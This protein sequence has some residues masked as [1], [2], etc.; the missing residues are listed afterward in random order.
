MRS[1]RRHRRQHVL[2]RFAQSDAAPVASPRFAEPGP[3]KFVLVQTAAEFA[4]ADGLLSFEEPASPSAGDYSL[5]ISQHP[6]SATGAIS[7][8]HQQALIAT[9]A[10]ADNGDGKGGY[11]GFWPTTT[12]GASI[13]A[14]PHVA[15]NASLN[16]ALNFWRPSACSGASGNQVAIVP[17][18]AGGW[19]GLYRYAA[20]GVPWTLAHLDFAGSSAALCAGWS[21]V[22][23]EGSLGGLRLTRAGAAPPA[24]IDVASPVSLAE[25]SAPADLLADFKVTQG[26]SLVD[27]HRYE[28][29][30]RH[31][32]SENFL[33]VGTVVSGGV[34]VLY[35]DQ[36]VAGV[37]TTIDSNS[38]V[39]S[40]GASKYI[41]FSAS[42]SAGS[43][44]VVVTLRGS[45]AATSG[46]LA[47]LAVA[48]ESGLDNSPT[49]V[50]LVFGTGALADLIVYP[51]RWDRLERR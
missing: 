3:G 50:P 34:V 37:R 23:G 14:G 13:E 47:S 2:E 26:G 48:V 5:R 18:A 44:A 35:V 33:A 16:D 45:R 41:Q 27:N 25:Y 12:L 7:R 36:V 17:R 40:A 19:F 30:F 28:L 21:N 46:W 22:D 8:A 31:T 38:G 24:S 6:G 20:L 29:R 9:L 32:D 43:T 10:L 1:V 49:V 51:G 15:W 42:T 39:A 11:F 4:V